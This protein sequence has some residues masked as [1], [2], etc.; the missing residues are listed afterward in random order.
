M[1]LQLINVQ[2]SS[3]NKLVNF[4]V[5]EREKKKKKEKKEANQLCRNEK[6]NLSLYFNLS[7]NP[8]FIRIPITKKKKKI[9]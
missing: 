2:K 7:R 6:L 5:I 8:Q 9:T 4:S 3:L 1:S